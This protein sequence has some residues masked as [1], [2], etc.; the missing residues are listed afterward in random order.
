MK[1]V[2]IEICD[3]NGELVTVAMS[4]QVS[5]ERLMQILDV[6]EADDFPLKQHDEGKT[7]KTSKDKMLDVI[8][9]QLTKAW[10][11]SKDLS[12]LYIE[13]YHEQIK[14]STVSTYLSR[15]YSNGYLERNGNR[16]CWQ[17]RLVTRLNNERH[18]V[19]EFVET[20][21]KK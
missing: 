2:K 20:L 1:R 17:Y 9:A 5:K 10:F 14:S 7:S 13:R 21:R 6:F 3:N 4:G 11:T 8:N 19:T 18:E 12:L 15:L 16:S